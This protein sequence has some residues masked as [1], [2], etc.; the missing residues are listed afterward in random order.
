[1]ADFRTRKMVEANVDATRVLPN[2][3]EFELNELRF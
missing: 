2:V 1:M 3:Q